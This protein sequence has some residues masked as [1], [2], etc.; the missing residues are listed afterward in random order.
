M[1]SYAELGLGGADDLWT[2]PVEKTAGWGQRK[3]W[4]RTFAAFPTPGSGNFAPLPAS[5]SSNTLASN[6]PAADRLRRVAE[7]VDEAKHLFDPNALTLASPAALPLQ[8][9]KLL[10]HDRTGCFAC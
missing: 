5:L 10:L 8:E 3:P 7:A 1:G 4:I 6:C 2:R 9:T